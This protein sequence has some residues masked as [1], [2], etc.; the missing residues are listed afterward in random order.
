MGLIWV[1]LALVLAGALALPVLT[2]WLRKPMNADARTGA[3]GSFV[4]LS[5]G[6]TH[7][8]WLGPTRGPVAVCVHGLTTPSFVW[9]ALARGLA[10]LG[11]RVLIYDLYGRGYSDRPRGRQDRRFFLDQLNE[12]LASQGVD[13]KIT[14][15]GYSMGGSIATAWAA[16]NPG[17]IDRL[18]LI[19]SAGVNTNAGRLAA[20]IRRW[21]VLGD[22][23]ML[24]FFAR[25][26]RKASESERGQTPA[27]GGIVDLQQRELEFRGFVPAVLSSMRGILSGSSE[28]D[29]RRLANTGAPV[30]A[31][32][33]QEDPLIPVSSAGKLAEWNRGAH[34]DA[35]EGA[36]HSVTYTHAGD[37]LS[38]IEADLSAG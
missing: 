25:N 2:E 23:L 4:T 20:F 35:I 27:I 6:V 19:A 24:A 3:E 7:L 21:P 34:Q 32:W 18:I 11:Y 9:R 29:H 12:L 36:D 5:R 13:G 15:L 30:L 28:A 10:R 14:L 8:D 33:G 37:I 26:H 38:V 31:I 22:W 1:I 16:E 17:R